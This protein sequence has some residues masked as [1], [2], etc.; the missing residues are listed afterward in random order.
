M[1]AI[2]T[3]NL[4][5][6]FGQSVHAVD[7]LDLTVEEGEVFGFLGPNG[8][9]KSTTIN[10]LLDFVRPSSGS[11]TVLGH[12]AQAESTA[13][14]KQIGV[15]P[16]GYE[17]YPRLS[18]KAH[19]EMAIELKDAADD[20]D[21][22]IETV[23][24]APDDAERKAG[25]YSQGMRQRL[26]LGMAIAGDP[27]LLILDEPTNGLDPNGAREL[28]EIVLDHA[29]DGATVFFSSHIL[30]QVRAV[31]DRVGILAN[32]QLVAVDTIDGLREEM[33]TGS[34]MT[35]TVDAVPQVDL[36][37]V[38]GISDAKTQ[39]NTVEVTVA[40]SAAKIQ[41]IDRVREAGAAIQDIQTTEASL[42]SLFA[43]Y[44]NGGDRA[45]VRA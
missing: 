1:P 36:S 35:L 8:A 41:V 43:A 3:Q 45:E 44:T 37:K 16:E 39:P 24:L 42:E 34:T 2:E 40:D 5:K 6:V 21:D 33:G 27:E 26:A 11:A 12:D 4:T 23:G 25:D 9:G 32:G 13:I 18:G 20:P 15:L 14:R 28:R 29:E 38:P 7:G 22:I 17:L 19:V 30:E 10:M 31:C